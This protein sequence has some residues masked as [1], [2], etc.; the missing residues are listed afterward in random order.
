MSHI[1]KNHVNVWSI[2]DC[3]MGWVL[4]EDHCYSF[5]TRKERYANAVVS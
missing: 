2:P 5:S 3:D 1:K 4:Y